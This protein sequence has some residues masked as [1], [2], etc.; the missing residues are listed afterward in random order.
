MHLTSHASTFATTLLGFAAALLPSV[1]PS[2]PL[3]AQQ[4]VASYPLLA[5]L[6][7]TTGNH[8]PMIL[9]GTPPPATPANGVCV[10]GIYAFNP[11]GQD[12]RTPALP[13]LDTTDF[14][15]DV[16]FNVAA[17]PASI[18]PIL[19]GGNSY[20]WIGIY[21]QS[22]G[23]IGIKH[24]NSNLSW[25]TTSPT[26]GR[27]YTASLRF[28]AGTAEL[29]LDGRLI[30]S[31]TTGTLNTGNNLN[32]TTNDYSNGRNHN[33]CIRHLVISN[34]TTLGNAASAANYGGS[35]G[36]L[37][38]S[39]NGRP[40]IGNATFGLR[41]TNVPVA[42]PLAHVAMGTS[43]LHP[44][45]E[46]SAIGM[47]GCYSHTNFSVGILGPAPATS[48][49]ATLPLPIPNDPTLTGLLLTTQAIGFSPATSLGVITSNGTLLVVG[50]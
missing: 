47:A 33:G 46:L 16:E 13:T 40:Q 1:I 19:M 17:L 37:T 27:W 12:A 29:Y 9:T 31:V 3:H 5:D 50:T 43:N 2:A 41:I 4:P 36:G 38:L 18:A 39:A 25:S 8:G 11:G 24:N 10:N 30:H 28:E 23:L 21:M 15:V 49:V 26:V 35:C 14:Q 42:I 20:R 6:V 48:G 34:N 7:D 32:F 22:T 44:E 45:V